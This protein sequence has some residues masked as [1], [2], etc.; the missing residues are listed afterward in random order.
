MS[1]LHPETLLVTVVIV[2]TPDDDGVPMAT[3]LTR[4]WESCNVQQ[5]STIEDRGGGEVVTVK[6]HASGPL[7]EWITSESLVD[8]N[9]TTYRVEGEP[10]HFRG[11]ALNH[12]EINLIGWEG[13]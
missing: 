12:T 13:Q 11:G 10:A 6:L 7:A 5:S 3:T 8:W 1:L 4:V 2:G 9:G